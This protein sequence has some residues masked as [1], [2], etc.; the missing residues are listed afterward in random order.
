M[1]NQVRS[2][3]QAPYNA[4]TFTQEDDDYV[5]SRALEI[6]ESRL[7]KP[8]AALT[9]P[10]AARDLCAL[11]LG[12][13]EHEVFAVLFLDNRHR[14]IAFE[15][16]FRGTIDGSSVHPREV[17]KRALQLNAQAVILSHNH[18][19]QSI[20]PSGADRALTSRL[21]DV[22]GMVDIRVLDHILVGGASSMSFA[23]DGII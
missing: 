23:E 21:K 16:M 4:E 10:G 19:S 3:D 20:E 18:P 14:L 2:E 22:L 9:S 17:L 13:L 7:R 15:E 8:G 11:R 6:L 1:K 5:I 12:H